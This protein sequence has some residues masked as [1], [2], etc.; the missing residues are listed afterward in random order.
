MKNESLQKM[1]FDFDINFTSVCRQ[2]HCKYF[3]FVLLSFDTVLVP[4]VAA[5]ATAEP[6]APNFCLE[7]GHSIFLQS[8]VSLVP[9]HINCHNWGAHCC[10]GL[11]SAVFGTALL[12]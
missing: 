6:A 5:D 7:H 9:S 10:G 11:Q 12:H 1:F 3:K 8:L 4:C 2:V